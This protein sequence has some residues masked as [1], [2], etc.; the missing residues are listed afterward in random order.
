MKVKIWKHTVGFFSIVFCIV[1]IL[2]MIIISIIKVIKDYH[3]WAMLVLFVLFLIYFLLYLIFSK[4]ALSKVVF[5]ED[6][7]EW[8]RFKKQIAFI[9][10]DE[11][12][13]VLETPY[14]RFTHWLTFM[15][16]SKRIDIDVLSKKMYNAI[17]EIC[18]EPNIR[19]MINEI[20]SLKYF[21]RDK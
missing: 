19:M 14:G 4:N 20:N 11:I 15:S 5:S 6:G 8:I 9:R 21:H 7:I 12:T 17:I 1:L 2:I 10:W 13:D 16:G 18:P 3:Y